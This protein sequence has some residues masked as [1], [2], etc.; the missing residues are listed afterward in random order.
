MEAHKLLSCSTPKEH[1]RWNS[2]VH[3]MQCVRLWNSNSTRILRNVF[4][5][6]ISLYI[7]LCF[8]YYVMIMVSNRWCIL[9]HSVL[10]LGHQT[11]FSHDGW[12]KLG[13]KI[14]KFSS[15]FS[16]SYL[17]VA[18]PCAH[19]ASS[20]FLNVSSHTARCRRSSLKRSS[21][22]R[23]TRKPVLLSTWRHPLAVVD[24]G[25]GNAGPHDGGSAAAWWTL[26]WCVAVGFGRNWCWYGDIVAAADLSSASAGPWNNRLGGGGIWCG[27]VDP[28]AARCEC[29]GLGWN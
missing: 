21:H 12:C 20:I 13:T 18:A 5:S 25:S 2:E 26:R 4:S 3:P 28:V 17:H 24:V 6:K 9:G 23:T 27:E 29:R 15:N 1:M 10:G 8:V 14:G 7:Q 11:L 22:S 19:M 16:R